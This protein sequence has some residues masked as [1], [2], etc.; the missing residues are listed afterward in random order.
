MRA[1]RYFSGTKSEA[2]AE[3]LRSLPAWP[4]AMLQVPAAKVVRG[5]RVVPVLERGRMAILPLEGWFGS[6]E[7][8]AQVL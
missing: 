6:L 2:R 3:P 7:L 4:A 1:W 5:M 8:V